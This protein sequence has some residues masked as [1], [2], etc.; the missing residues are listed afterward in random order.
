MLNKTRGVI[1]V[2][3]FYCDSPLSVG[4]Y[5]NLLARLK[6]Q[7]GYGVIEVDDFSDNSYD[8]VILLKSPNKGALNLMRSVTKL[9]RDT[10]VVLYLTDLHSNEEISAGRSR[11]NYDFTTTVFYHRLKA[12]C[13]RADLILCPYKHSF[14]RKFPEHNKKFKFF[15]HFVNNSFVKDLAS[16]DSYRISRKKC[17]LAGATCPYIYPMRQVVVNYIVRTAGQKYFDILNHPG[18]FKSKFSQSSKIGKDFLKHIHRYFAAVSTASIFDYVV[19][20]Y[21]EIP[22]VGTLLLGG[23]ATDLEDL[24]FVDGENYVRV[25]PHN[26]IEKAIDVLENKSKFDYIRLA[27]RDLVLSTYTDDHAYTNLLKYMEEML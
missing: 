25:T 4:R 6:E 12:L 9:G 2:P 26:I 16:Y 5:L 24:G 20:K 7:F 15:P 11:V 23:Q 22:A 10:K 3:K 18:Y 17:L 8:V 13:D 14:L 1:V 21:F 27:G 19:C